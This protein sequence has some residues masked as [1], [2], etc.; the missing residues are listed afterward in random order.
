MLAVI[1]LSAH[2]L[3]KACFFLLVDILVDVDLSTWK[4]STITA[5]VHETPRSTLSNINA[6]PPKHGPPDDSPEDY[7]RRSPKRTRLSNEEVEAAADAILSILLPAP[8]NNTSAAGTSTP[9]SSSPPQGSTPPRHYRQRIEI[10]RHLD[11]R[12]ED[13]DHILERFPVH[14]LQKHGYLS[15]LPAPHPQPS[16]AFAGP[17]NPGP[18]WDPTP[19]RPIHPIFRRQ[20]WLNTSDADWALLQP[21]LH[22]ATRILEEEALLHFWGAVIWG[23]HH[24]QAM[25]KSNVRLG[26]VSRRQRRL[27]RRENARLKSE[28]HTDVGIVIAGFDAEALYDGRAMTGHWDNEDD[29][30]ARAYLH[31][32]GILDEDIE[33]DDDGGEWARAEHVRLYGLKRTWKVLNKMQDFVTWTWKDSMGVF[34]ST[35]TADEPGLRGK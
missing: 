4:S 5:V 10:P 11:L 13:K 29:G 17:T 21:A 20:N 31:R 18:T 2:C 24:H 12:A 32:V 19:S 27:L 16:P 23:P 7:D 1:S 6:M 3:I 26:L 34:G 28:N 9:S 15:H 8:F 14:L 22:L 30:G 35:H 25:S 33:G